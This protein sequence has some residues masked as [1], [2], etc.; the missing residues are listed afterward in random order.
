MEKI[1][2]FLASSSELKTDRE[3]F[4]LFI[5]RKNKE[6]I[7]KGAFIELIIWEDFLDTLSQTRLQDEYNKAIKQCDIFVM[8]FF[9]KVG[10]F[11]EEEFETAF[12]QFKTTSKPLIYT[13]FKVGPIINDSI[14]EEEMNSLWAFQKKLKA[15]GHFYTKYENID[16][17]QFKFSQQLDKLA[18]DGYFTF[19]SDKKSTKTDLIPDLSHL[20]I[21][22][23][24]LVG[25][26]E[27]LDELN[28]YFEDPR[29]SMV[30][31]IA[32]GGVGKSAITD[33]W[34]NRMA[35][36]Y[37]GAK[38]VFGWSFYSQGSH[39]T[40]T[41]STP[42]YEAIFPFFGWKGNLPTSEDAKALELASLLNQQRSLL[43][44]DGIE[45][46]QNNPEIQHGWVADT[47]LKQLLL[48][49]GRNGLEKGGLILVSSRQ[50]IIELEKHK[51]KTYRE[52]NLETLPPEEGAELLQSLGVKKYERAEN[53]RDELVKTSEEFGGHALA[54]VLL[55]KM[56]AQKYEGD[57]REK[58]QIPSLFKEKEQGVHAKRVM[59]HYESLWP[60]DS[61]EILFLKMLGLFDR[62]MGEGERKVLFEKAGFAK[63]LA[64][65]KKDQWNDMTKRLREAGLL[66]ESPDALHRKEWDTHPLVRS[67]FGERFREGEEEKWKEAHKA[68]F[69]YFR[70]L[71]EKKQPD[72]PEELAPLYR[73]MTHG[74]LAGAYK[75]AMDD[76][77]WERIKRGG[78]YYS[79]QKLGLYAQ[80]LAAI[81]GFFP[82]GWESPVQSSLSEA[83]QGWLLGET[84]FCLMSLGRMQEAVAPRRART[85]IA[86][87]LEDWNNASNSAESLVNLLV[88]T[89]G[90]E[91]ALE[92]AEKGIEWADK[93]DGR[94]RQVISRSKSGQ[95][96]FHLGNLEASLEAFKE[97]EKIQSEHYKDSPRLRTLAGVDYCSLLL[98]KGEAEE[99][100]DRGGYGLEISA[101]N[102][103]LMQ[104]AMDHLTLGRS[105]EALGKKEEAKKELDLAVDG[106]RRAGKVQYM[107]IVLL[108][109]AAFF[110]RCS[111]LEAARKDLEEAMEIAER[112][113][114]VLYEADGLL[115]SG[116]YAVSSMQKDK[117]RGQTTEDEKARGQTTE[118]GGKKKRRAEDWIAH[119]KEAVERAEEMI[120]EMKYGLRYAEV[121]LLKSRIAAAEGKK[122]GAESLLNKARKRAEEMGQVRVIKLIE[123][124][125]H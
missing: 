64:A 19:K 22:T 59:S 63:P 107:P 76:V 4:E 65:L 24:P 73:A 112:C 14:I 101:R 70:D 38:K 62:P 109:R 23:T 118:D 74:C 37:K 85:K 1:K 51:G 33:E 100:L 30:S 26:K 108:N 89:R 66:L 117:G 34:L 40:A 52:T 50:P 71:P 53:F 60:K 67:F 18:N 8:L 54:L 121:D 91:E 81:S 93:T 3:Q 77:Y 84:S 86:E 48:H 94:H 42:F 56:I 80:D 111:D 25:R 95:T 31:I 49:I 83:D 97:A 102:N 45:P 43:V 16:Q 90:L 44:L 58:D 9:N 78:V 113:G 75:T 88:F 116:Q 123:S 119:A 106:M 27:R 105:L 72:T 82:E 122:E 46:L 98:E 61:P 115:L 11:T 96:Y 2:I 39:Q 69:D 12:G 110:L 114:M 36:K 17:L 6:W 47:G 21:P 28:T 32:P 120:T 13:Y 41:N 20:P 55:G 57:L 5:N 35:P 79:T 15:L 29:I 125:G 103:W 10:K 99:A 104:M 124:L 92:V 87:K 7:G 68:L